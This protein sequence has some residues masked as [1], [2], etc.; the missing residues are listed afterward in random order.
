MKIT[1][2]V[3][4]MRCTEKDGIPSKLSSMLYLIV[5]P[6]ICIASSVKVTYTEKQ[7]VT[8]AVTAYATFLP[9]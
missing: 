5:S 4:R 6:K 7:K 1:I 2:K 3:I 8:L 9:V